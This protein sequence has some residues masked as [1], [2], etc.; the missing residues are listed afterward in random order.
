V[1]KRGREKR[2]QDAEALGRS[3]DGFLTKIPIA[4]DAMGNLVEFLLTAGQEADVTQAEAL[5]EGHEAEAVIADKGYDS[6]AP[7]RAVKERRAEAVIP[8]KESGTSWDF[9]TWRR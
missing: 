4:V 5:I 9:S 8:P 7:V 1:E 2:G 6:D 3:R